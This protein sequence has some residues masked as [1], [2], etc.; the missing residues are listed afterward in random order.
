MSNQSVGNVE[1][2]IQVSNPIRDVIVHLPYGG[3]EGDIVTTGNNQI[4]FNK[5]LTDPSNDIRATRLATTGDDVVISGST[6][7]PGAGYILESTSPTTADWVPFSPAGTG[8]NVGTSGVG[9]YRDT[10][11]STLNFKKLRVTS[12]MSILDDTG[13][14]TVAFDVNESQLNHN[15]LLNYV[16]NQHVDHSLVSISTLANSGLSG[17][18]NIT[19]TRNISL[20]INNLVT[21]PSPDPTSDYVAIYDASTLSTRKALISGL[22]VN[23]I[24]TVVSSTTPTSVSSTTYTPMPGMSATPSAG[25]Y[26]IT[27]SSMGSGDSNMRNYEYGVFVNGVLQSD[28]YRRIGVSNNAQRN[29]VHVLY[30]KAAP[31][32][33]NG[34]DLVDI[35]FKVDGAACTF[36][37]YERN[38][39]LK[40]LSTP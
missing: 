9:V 22:T 28:S 19:A 31:V 24:Y 7:P 2:G 15:A 27:F 32:T 36:S 29:F 4:I 11:G 17:G 1:F 13:T 21:E 34:T 18:G 39:I 3:L 38:M 25:T 8:A 20:N 5:D 37:V 23:T 35:S 6:Q 16:A 14:D 40:R 10:I 12:R 26:E 33:V 30:T